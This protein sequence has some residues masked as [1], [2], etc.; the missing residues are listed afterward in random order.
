[1]ILARRLLHIGKLRDNSLLTAEALHHRSDALTS[2]AA[3]AG[4]LIAVVGGPNY[5]MADPIAALLVT[6]F[7]WWNALRIGRTAF[8]EIMDRSPNRDWLDLIR[9]EASRVRGVCGIDKCR[10]RKSGDRWM[11]EIHVMVDGEQTVASGHEIGHAV[12][13][14]LMQSQEFG[15]CEVVVHLEPAIDSVST[16]V[17]NQRRIS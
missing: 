4:I 8:D 6:P 10:A 5:A 7:I 14:H 9:E 2:L 3:F 11:L 16:D 12:Q 1:E 13:R 15:L 17:F